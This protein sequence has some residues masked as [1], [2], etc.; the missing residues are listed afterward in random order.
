MICFAWITSRRLAAALLFLALPGIALALPRASSVPGG[1]A[2]ITLGVVSGSTGPPRAWFGEQRV[3]VT[4]ADGHWVAV[5]GLAL[6]LPPG[7]HQLRVN[8]GGE[9]KIL[10]FVVSAKNYPEQR[11]TLKDSSKVNLSPADEARA[12]SEI[13]VIQE[14]KRHWRDVDDTDSNFLQPAEGRLASRFGLRRI[15]NGE[16]RSPHSGLDVAVPRGTPIKA[17]AQGRVLAV[18][19][20]FFNGN[21]VFIDHGNGLISM[22]CHLDRIDVQAGDSVAQGQH[23][24]RS[25]MTGRASGPHLHWSVVLNGVMVDPEL[26]I[27]ASRRVR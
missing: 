25:G 2:L 11:I 17:S 4:S 19:D 12:V 16:P 8:V 10:P 7:R 27:A 26:F 18:D 13:A 14:L 6:D 5:L 1:I 3:L 24:G 15:F 20:Y 9:E 23:I 22:Y 21:T